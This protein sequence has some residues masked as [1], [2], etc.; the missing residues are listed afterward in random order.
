MSEDSKLYTY[1]GVTQIFYDQNNHLP[2]DERNNL[3]DADGYWLAN[4]NTRPE[5]EILKNAFEQGKGILNGESEWS[6]GTVLSLS[7]IHI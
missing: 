1:S 4:R 7:L 5:Y 2:D 3:R 6:A